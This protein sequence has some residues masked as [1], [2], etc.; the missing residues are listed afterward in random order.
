MALYQTF[1]HETSRYTYISAIRKG[2]EFRNLLVHRDATLFSS[3]R[4][5]DTAL[6]R[7]ELCIFVCFIRFAFQKLLNVDLSLS[8]V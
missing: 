4:I 2:S 1:V 3:R 6:I 7:N 8:Y 5:C